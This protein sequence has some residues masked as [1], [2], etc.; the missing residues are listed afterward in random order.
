[1]LEDEH[2]GRQM[3]YVLV[4]F[5]AIAGTGGLDWLRSVGSV[6]DDE[7][8]HLA[9]KVLIYGLDSTTSDAARRRRCADILPAIRKRLASSVTV[10]S[11][12]LIHLVF[13]LGCFRLDYASDD[14]PVDRSLFTDVKERK[15]G[16]P[17][18]R[19]HRR[20]DHRHRCCSLHLVKLQLTMD[21]LAGPGMEILFSAKANF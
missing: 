4:R 1:M 21:A 9:F 2:F 17:G 16:E 3:D 11:Q 19:R 14:E 5:Y 20:T 7:L 18:Q 10:Q 13:L 8:V 6:R 15:L 12:N